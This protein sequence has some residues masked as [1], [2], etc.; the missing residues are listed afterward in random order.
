[1]PEDLLAA[2]R[3]VL[4]VLDGLGWTQLE[5][6]RAELPTLSSLAGRAIT[7]VAPTTTATAL[8]SITTGLTPGVHGIVGYRMLVDR[9]VLNVLR[10]SAEG[11]DARGAIPPEQ[12]QP[13]PVFE[14]QRPPVI[15][16]AEFRD[17]GFTRAHLHQTR[18]AGWRMPSTLVTEVAAAVGR[19]EPFV[20]AYYDG[21][22]KIAHE[23]GLGAHYR[24]ELRAAD[25]LVADLLEVIGDAA[26]VVISDHGQVDVG[27]Q[28]IV[29]DPAVLAH[30]D[31][32]SGE[33]R[34]RWLHARPGHARQLLEAAAAHHAD[35]AW[36]LGVDEVIDEGWFGPEVTDAARS[37]LG[38]VALVARDEVSFVD[39]A[40]TGLFELRARHGSLTEAE[41]LVPFLY[42][43]GR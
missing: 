35:T 42:R 21:I 19:D 36:V 31:Q 18:L 30:V 43:T 23:F 32:Q 38:D 37:R 16:R 17:T 40:D 10:W 41:M 22:D 27:D 34:F 2:E 14:A 29:P 8:T 13:H 24:A 28:V 4:L 15:T 39:P 12:T 7:S 9:R 3:I 33:G 20:Y 26:L 6:H 1:M 11:R 5:Q 25:R